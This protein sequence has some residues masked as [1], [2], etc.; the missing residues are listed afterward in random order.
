MGLV[1]LAVGGE[2]LYPVSPAV[3]R[4]ELLALAAL[5]IL[6]NGVCGVQYI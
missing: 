5:I 4:P 3:V 1:P 6:Y 2:G